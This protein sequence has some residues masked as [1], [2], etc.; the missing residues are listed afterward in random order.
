MDA[1]F[2]HVTSG[3]GKLRQLR[4]RVGVPRVPVFVVLGIGPES[5]QR[6]FGNCPGLSGT[7]PEIMSETRFEMFEIG[8]A[9]AG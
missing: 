3:S 2:V 9:L 8:P 1:K 7:M 6:V 5:S 4:D